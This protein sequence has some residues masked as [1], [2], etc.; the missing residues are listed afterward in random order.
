M[1]MSA[2]KNIG[3]YVGT[4]QAR[5]FF[6]RKICMY[7]TGKGILLRK[8]CMYITGISILLRQVLYHKS[9]RGGEGGG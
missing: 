6:L 2:V 1:G 5:V 3:M 8:I 4:S 7:I 9:E